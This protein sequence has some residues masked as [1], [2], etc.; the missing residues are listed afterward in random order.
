MY[1]SQN[2][3]HITKEILTQDAL[4]I[5]LLKLEAKTLKRKFDIYPVNRFYNLPS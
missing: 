4:G 5:N 1:S 2:Y 3:T